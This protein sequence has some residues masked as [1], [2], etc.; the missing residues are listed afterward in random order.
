MV[1][2][3]GRAMSK[4]VRSE[5]AI[6]IAAAATRAFAAAA[7]AVSRTRRRAQ[8]AAPLWLSVLL[9]ICSA[10]AASHA[11]CADPPQLIGSV[12]TPPGANPG[13]YVAAHPSTGSSYYTDDLVPKLVQIPPEFECGHWIETRNFDHN[14]TAASF[15]TFQLLER[16]DVYVLYDKRAATEADRRPPDWLVN[17]FSYESVIVDVDTVGNGGSGVND[18]DM[19]FVAYRKS[20]PA[21]SVTLGANAATGADFI[22][23]AGTLTPAN[24]LVVVTKPRAHPALPSCTVPNLIGNIVPPAGGG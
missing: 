14:A 16:A 8:L 3:P 7:G 2:P 22:S 4:P 12:T 23:A 24:Y 10:P 18:A 9:A 1:R 17:N 15:L 5:I 19:E 13:D 21:G 20:Y 11:A 6:G